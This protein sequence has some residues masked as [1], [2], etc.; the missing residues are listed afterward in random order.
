MYLTNHIPPSCYLASELERSPLPK[1]YRTSNIRRKVQLVC[2]TTVRGESKPGRSSPDLRGLWRA[3]CDVSVPSS[4]K[5][6]GTL[7]SQ[8]GRRAAAGGRV[9][10]GAESGARTSGELR[11]FCDR[12]ECSLLALWEGSCLNGRSSRPRC[13]DW[14][15]DVWRTSDSRCDSPR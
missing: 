11:S 4:R 7:A 9:T 3:L 8:W 5:K 13:G 2:V 10:D 6:P 15:G 14:Y 12:V 1:P